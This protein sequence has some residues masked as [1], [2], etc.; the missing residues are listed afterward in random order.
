MSPSLE[1]RY[2]RALR[3]YPSKWRAAN[4]DVIVGTLLD[5]A[6]GRET[7]RRGELVNL[8]ANGLLTR[9]SAIANLLPAGVRDRASSVALGFGTGVVLVMLVV[10]EWAPWAT[11]DPYYPAPANAIGP[12]HG[13]GGVLYCVWVVSFVLA[14]V[15]ASRAARVVLATSIIFAIALSGMYTD[16]WWLRPTNFAL[17]VL[18]ALAFIVAMGNPRGF[19]GGRVFMLASAIFGA[20]WV[21]VPFARNVEWTTLV[22]PREIWS[23][24]VYGSGNGPML[25]FWLLVFAVV[26]FIARKWSWFGALALLATPWVGLA[27]ATLSRQT[28]GGELV[29]A[30]ALV[31]GCIVAALVILYVRG[32]RVAIVRRQ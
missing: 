19:R 1:Q 24:A 20:G 32:Y 25:M 10:Q 22:T 15:G 14:S 17:A 4:G 5:G 7:P 9:F 28:G 8:A 29:L 6:E 27:L 23:M 3:W 12:F 26:A 2:R 13:W 16:S 30:G 31:A 21:L 18:G 11:P